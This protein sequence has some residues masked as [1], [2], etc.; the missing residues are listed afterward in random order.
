VSYQPYPTSGGQ[1][2]V[3]QAPPAEAPPSVRTAV[4]FMYA[5]AALSAIGLILTVVTFHSLEVAVRNAAPQLSVRQAH[6]T[7]VGAVVVAVVVGLIGIGLWLWMA[8][9]N[10]AGKN[11][12]R[13][14]STVLFGL[15]TLALIAGF[16]RAGAALSRI[17]SLLIW[18]AGLGAIVF[19]WRRE[20]SDY[21][22]AG[23]SL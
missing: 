16:V 20:A 12:G 8:W 6:A 11:W 14:T 13:I 4:M 23:R 18:L 19:L 15:N 1:P 10:K 7:A 21:F 2:P 5:G 17:S 9:A 22:E 3:Q